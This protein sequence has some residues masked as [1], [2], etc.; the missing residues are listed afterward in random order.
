MLLDVCDGFRH[1]S[2]DGG[3]Q[4]VG[5]IVRQIQLNIGLDSCQ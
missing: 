5:N 3:L 1:L 2:E 4:L